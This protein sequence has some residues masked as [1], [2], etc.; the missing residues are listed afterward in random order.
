MRVRLLRNHQLPLSDPP[1][2]PLSQLPLS[3][4]LSQLPL[5]PLLLQ[6]PLSPLSLQLLLPSPLL[7]ENH[8]GLEL[9][10]EEVPPEVAGLPEKKL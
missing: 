2:P 10:L 5:S 8:P 6:L 7:N 3:P 1:S 9:V 4:P